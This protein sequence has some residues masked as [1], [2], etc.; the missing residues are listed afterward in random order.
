MYR[1]FN[2]GTLSIAL[3]YKYVEKFNPLGTYLIMQGF[4]SILFTCCEVNLHYE[5][6]WLIKSTRIF[7]PKHPSL[8]KKENVFKTTPKENEKMLSQRI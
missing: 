7:S 1:K 6:K 2:A 4:S 3:A 8:L 5:S